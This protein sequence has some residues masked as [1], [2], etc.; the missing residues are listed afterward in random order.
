MVKPS[1]DVKETNTSKVQ[2]NTEK[3]KNTPGL[4]ALDEDDEFEEFET[5]GE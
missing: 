2:S 1:T 4:G 3:K 5:E